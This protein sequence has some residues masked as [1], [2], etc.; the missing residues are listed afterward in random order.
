M[1]T[2][3]KRDVE[4]E[5]D[6]NRTVGGP[7]RNLLAVIGIDQYQHWRRLG[8]AVRDATG[9]STV[10]EGLGF[11]HATAPLLDHQATGK[12]MWA[13]VTQEL[14]MLGPNDRLVLF[15]AGHGATKKHE[16]GTD[17]VKT[18]YLVPVDAQHEVFTWVDLEGW[19]RAVALLPAKHI[20]V[21]LDACHSGI[22]LG[23]VIK[24]RDSNSW[25]DEP[26]SKLK[27]RRSRRIITSALDD[28]VALD[29]GPLHGHSLFTG[30]LIEALTHGLRRSSSRVTTGSELGAYVQRRVESYPYSQQTPDF[31]A[32]AFDDRG[33]MVISMVERQRE[34][35][36]MI[37]DVGPVPIQRQPSRS[38]VR[39][40]GA[41]SRLMVALALAAL[42][43]LALLIWTI[44]LD[45]QSRTS[46]VE[47]RFVLQASPELLR[48]VSG[49]TV[50]RMLKHLRS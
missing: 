1:L 44:V 50:L 31:G 23:P 19:L 27:M 40:G 30:C 13:L 7:G 26:L 15:F 6:L 4:V 45:K 16:L 2:S 21:I 49:T 37:D 18:G 35:M 11:A 3:D 32:F 46:A 20:L 12:A 25:R 42:G 28:Q 39:H 43:A 10:L 14:R 22:A 38:S 29:S 33:E 9:V 48:G 8:N 17:V 34:V 36:E 47:T 24:W 41:R 5:S